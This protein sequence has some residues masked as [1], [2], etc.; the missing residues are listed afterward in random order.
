[1]PAN[2]ANKVTMKPAPLLKAMAWLSFIIAY[3]CVY[4][5]I[6]RLAAAV[7]DLFR[8]MMA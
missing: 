1:M 3:L 4:G 2:V 8:L 7:H 6:S 5:L